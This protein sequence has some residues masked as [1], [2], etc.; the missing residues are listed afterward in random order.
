MAKI[1]Y[2]GIDL[3]VC[4]DSYLK[5]F[6]DPIPPRISNCIGL[7][8]EEFQDA[9]R[10]PVSG[11]AERMRV[12]A[13]L[14]FSEYGEGEIEIF[15]EANGYY[16]DDHS[17]MFYLARYAEETEAQVKARVSLATQALALRT[18]ATAKKKELAEAKK[19]EKL[20]ASLAKLTEAER[21]ELLKG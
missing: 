7:R 6:L 4:H 9:I 10:G 2:Q 14:L 18:K 16:G 1:M 13:D 20:K 21:A 3:M 12:H 11:L 5:G 17:L 19:I 8:S 15:V